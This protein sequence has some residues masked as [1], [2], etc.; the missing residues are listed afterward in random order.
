MKE[1]WKRLAVEWSGKDWAF[2][3]AHAWEKVVKTTPT[4]FNLTQYA[5]NLRLCGKW[6]EAEKVFETVNIDEI[7]EGYAFTFY[8]RKGHLYKDQGQLD[9]ALECYQK[10]VSYQPDTTFPY[11]FLYEVLSIKGNLEEAEAVLLEAL[12]KEGDTDEVYYNLSINYARKGDFKKA[13]E[14]MKK[15]I[16]LYPEYPNA[17]KWLADFENMENELKVEKN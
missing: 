1:D 15:C 6:T 2:S 3:A 12:S 10:S 14:C 4:A 5:D 11:V 8:V 7:P 17:K 9:K 13:F 16:Q